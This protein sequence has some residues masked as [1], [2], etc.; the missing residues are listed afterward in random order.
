GNDGC[1]ISHRVRRLDASGCYTG[2]DQ[3]WLQPEAVPC[4]EPLHQELPG[5]LHSPIPTLCHASTLIAGRSCQPTMILLDRYLITTF[6]KA[7][8]ALFVSLVSLYVIIDAFSHFEE[9]LQAS[10][11]MQKTIT[12]TLSI[13]YSYQL[14]LIFDRL[15]G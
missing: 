7:W 12:E 8:L 1:V 15:C 13:Y 9:L 2:N 5:R 14:V 6:V 3:E 11:F 10:R 4:Q